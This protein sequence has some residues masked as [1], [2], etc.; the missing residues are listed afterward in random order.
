MAAAA[1]VDHCSRTSWNFRRSLPQGSDSIRTSVH[2][3][4]EEEEEEEGE[5]EEEEEE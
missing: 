3:T 4:E 1:A 2:R 5:E